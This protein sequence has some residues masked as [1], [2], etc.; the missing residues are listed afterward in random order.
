MQDLLLSAVMSVLTE[1]VS[2]S[3]PK[4]YGKDVPKDI[5]DKL[6][7]ILNSV[8][9]RKKISQAQFVDHGDAFGIAF[10]IGTAEY[11]LEIKPAKMGSY[12]GSLSLQKTGEYKKRFQIKGS[13]SSKNNFPSS[14]DIAKATSAISD[15]F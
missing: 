2:I 4:G 12:D 5:Q 1:K 7:K 10:T 6:S 13:A 8:T 14:S 3:P 9:D 15:L 11:Y